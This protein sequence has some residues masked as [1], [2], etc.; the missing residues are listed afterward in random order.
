MNHEFEDVALRLKGLRESLDLTAA[1]FAVS[2]DIP[3]D[4]YTQ[5]E[6]GDKDLTINLLK[7]IASHYN[8]DV[9]TLMFGHEPRMR[10][11]YL[12][13]KGKGQ[14]VNRVAAYKYQT[15]AG[16][17]NNRKADIFEVTVEPYVA[18]GEAHISTHSGQ[19]FILL[20]EGRMLIHIND[21]DLILEGGDSIYF[22]S[23]LP[24]GMEAL[25]GKQV[26]FLVVVL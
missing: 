15:L 3:L 17:F 25:D 4:V 21:K 10:S 9:S 18:N 7:K 23:S 6:S 22:D 13:R 1:Q 8:V 2:C 12:T 11:Y 14:S 16:G 26:K 20:L 24:H 5:Y 19:E